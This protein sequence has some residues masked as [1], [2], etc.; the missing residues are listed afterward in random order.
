MDL[1]VLERCIIPSCSIVNC[2]VIDSN[3]HLGRHLRNSYR[4]LVRDFRDSNLHLGKDLR[5][6]NLHLSV[7]GAAG[8]VVNYL[9]IF[10]LSAV[11]NNGGCAFTA[12]V[13]VFTALV[14]ASSASGRI[15]L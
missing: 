4:H 5:D 7:V 15:R 1:Q 10:L 8:F 14:F 3:F 9:A 2:K 11:H 12:L 6:A 13:C